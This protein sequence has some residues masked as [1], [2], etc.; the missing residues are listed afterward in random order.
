MIDINILTDIS[1]F[2][3]IVLVWEMH[4]WASYFIT[5]VAFTLALVF[6]ESSKSYGTS[7]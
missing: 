2:L 5:Y 6:E 4:S 7:L 1:N 3:W